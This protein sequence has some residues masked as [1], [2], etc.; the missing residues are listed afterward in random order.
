MYVLSVD[1]YMLSVNMYMLLVTM[2]IR[3]WHMHT[4]MTHTHTII[5]THTLPPPFPRAL[6]P[7][8]AL[9]LNLKSSKM[10][11]SQRVPLR[12]PA[13]PAAND[14][15]HYAPNPSPFCPEP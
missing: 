7:H 9:L 6:P 12:P 5:N 2:Y 11:I 15:L 14:N 8:L 1:M 3:T 4:S 10:F 13:V